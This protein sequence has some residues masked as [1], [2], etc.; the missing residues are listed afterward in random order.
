MDD[1]AALCSAS[2]NGLL[3]RVDDVAQE[4]H[5][6][7]AVDRC[8]DRRTAT[9]AA[10][11]A[12]RTAPSF[13]TGSV[14]DARHAEDGHLGLVDDRRERRAADA[15]QVGDREAAALHLVE[16]EL[17][18][19]RLLGQLRSAPRRARCTPFLSTSRR[20]G[21]SRPRSVSTAT[22][23]W[24]YCL[25]ITASP[26]MSTEALNCGNFLSAAASDLERDRGDG[27]LAASSAPR[28][29]AELLAQRL[30]VGDVGL[31]VLGD[32]RDRRPRRRPCA[33]PSCG[34]WR[35]SADARSGPT[36]R[37]RAGPPPAAAAAGRSA[38]R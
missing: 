21:T 16:R 28:A 3:E 15:A 30:E 31:L 13:H 7:G 18:G 26:A 12:A 20:T 25:R 4:A 32:V 33:R 10:S 22:P 34:G 1:R 6:V 11:G 36:S 29:L 8:G 17:A 5:A 37:S 24:T 14:R 23:M 27:Q 9:A 38:A 2:R 19:A 35:A